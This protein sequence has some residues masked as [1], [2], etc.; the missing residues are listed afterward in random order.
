MARSKREEAQRQR[1]DERR[2]R[3]ER[4]DA[5][6]AGDG[7]ELGH[8]L[9]EAAKT[10]AA[11]ATVGAAMAAVRALADRAGGGDTDTGHEATEPEP[12][13]EASDP[14]PAGAV[15]DALDDEPEESP[16]PRGGDRDWRPEPAE[17]AS[18]SDVERA[19]ET[20]REQLAA[21]V[22]KAPESVSGLERTRE[23]WTVTLEVVEVVRIPSSTDVLASYEVVLDDDLRLVRYR[24]CRRYHRSQ[25]EGSDRS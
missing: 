3:R 13:I 12:A 17:G 2:R 4:T 22:G 8:D 23:G 25:A 24:R 7:N 6:G 18:P 20:A 5:D 1:A 10:A 15:V 14:E 16:E 9:K 21:L 19:V 11:A